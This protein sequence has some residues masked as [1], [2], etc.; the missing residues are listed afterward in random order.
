MLSYIDFTLEGHEY[1][2]ISVY[3]PAE[4][5]SKKSYEFFSTL[6][7]QKVLDPFKHVIIAGDWNTART[8][9]YHHN[10]KDWEHYKPRTRQL[11][12]NG[13]LEH[14]LYDP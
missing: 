8:K 10:Y 14:S 13:I 1:R 5:E 11:I 12:N 7:D 2:F 3:A 6:F 4:N 9:I